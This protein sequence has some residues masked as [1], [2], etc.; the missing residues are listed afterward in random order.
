[1]LVKANLKTTVEEGDRATTVTKGKDTTKIEKDKVLT[2]VSGN[3]KNTVQKGNRTTDISA[4]S[5]TTKAM[6]SIELKVGSNSIKI[7]QTGVTIKGIKV[8]IQ[9]TATAEMKSPMTT[10]KADGILVL[11][12][13]LTKIN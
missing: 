8:T 11:Q 10:V 7:D 6:K 13:S 12:G 9:G 2:V 3:V 4:G 5:D 1:M